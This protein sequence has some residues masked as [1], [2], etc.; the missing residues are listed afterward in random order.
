MTPRKDIIRKSPLHKRSIQ[1]ILETKSSYSENPKIKIITS[2][3]ASLPL[4]GCLE[5]PSR[6]TVFHPLY[7][8][9]CI[10]LQTQL[11]PYLD[12]ICNLSQ[13]VIQKFRS[14]Q[15]SL[16]LFVLQHKVPPDWFKFGWAEDPRS[17]RKKLE[18]IQSNCDTLLNPHHTGMGLLVKE[19]ILGWF[20]T[21][22]SVWTK[23]RRSRW[24][25]REP[26]GIKWRWSC[27]ED[28]L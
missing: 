19:N 23:T 25:K 15:S 10:L 2:S 7:K 3:I 16:H 8:R 20:L 14:F 26:I 12:W 28:G 24:C 22:F 21:I 11:L 4:E 17:Q 1:Y 13:K 27:D 9:S 18:Y 6:C 5:T